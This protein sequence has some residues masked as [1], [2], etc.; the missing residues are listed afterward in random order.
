[1]QSNNKNQIPLS[2]DNEQPIL[3]APLTREEQLNEWFDFVTSI[4]APK[5]QR[6]YFERHFYNDPFRD[7]NSIFAARDKHG[8]ILGTVRVF[9]RKIVT[10]NYSVGE[11][12]TRSDMRGKGIATST[13]EKVLRLYEARWSV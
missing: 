9:H 2:Q 5:A 10:S 8:D 3:L 7:V 1:M 6:A 13:V 11:V 4:F 12:C